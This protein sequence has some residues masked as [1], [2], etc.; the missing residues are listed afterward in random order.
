M[1]VT[2]SDGGGSDGSAPSQTEW[3]Q[4]VS[5]FQGGIKDAGELLDEYVASVNDAL[6]APWCPDIVATPVRTQLAL[7]QALAKWIFSKLTE[8]I[9]GFWFPVRAFIIAYD[10][11][12]QVKNRF[13][14]VAAQISDGNLDI[15]NNWWG[16]AG[17]SYM[18]ASKG[19]SEA[20]DE[21]AEV[22]DDLRYRLWSLGGL[23]L[24]FYGSVA[25]LVAT[26]VKGL[27]A[28]VAGA[29]NPVSAPA[30]AP[31]A[32]GYTSA[33]ASGLQLAFGGFAAALTAE[34]EAVTSLHD[35]LTDNKIFKN[36]HWPLAVKPDDQMSD[37]VLRD[38]DA[39]AWR[40][41]HRD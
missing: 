19:Q 20:I 37:A 12:D 8:W 26:W 13:N 9:V 22:V 25:V 29:S 6:N 5:K 3:E 31:A 17:D 33:V 23:G 11:N 35:R 27:V 2:Q 15:D 30:S 16:A 40:I 14:D 41:R 1:A 4:F 24:A 7:L 39:P 34:I 18:F 38:G 36:G 10:W 28:S 21:I 32:V